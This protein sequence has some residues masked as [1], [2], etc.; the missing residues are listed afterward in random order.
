MIGFR[1]L[2]VVLFA[3]TGLTAA[4]AQDA[5]QVARQQLMEEIGDST[6]VLG[7]M[8]KGEQPYEDETAIEALTA[9]IENIGEFT[10]LFPEG[11][12]T[13][14]DTR[15]LPAIW[16]NKSDFEKHAQ[17]LQDA[18]MAARE[19]APGGKEAFVPAF[20]KMGKTCG[21][22]HEDFRAKKS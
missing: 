18:A 16:E 7:R 10:T 17:D 22:C 9:I 14:N 20:Q 2:V 1:P 19:V 21:A 13:G 8:V 3:S 5:P 11:T 12:E 6:Q 4:I 15:A